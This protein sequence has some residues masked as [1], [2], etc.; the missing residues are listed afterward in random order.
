MDQVVENRFVKFDEDL[1]KCFFLDHR[2]GANLTQHLK[3]FQLSL[4]KAYGQ[5]RNCPIPPKNLNTKIMKF[6][7]LIVDDLK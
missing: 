3:A 2:W 6:E 1:L 7:R 5:C 4:D